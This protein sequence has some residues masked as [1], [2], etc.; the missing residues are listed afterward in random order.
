MADDKTAGID[1]W[2]QV[3]WDQHGSDLLLADDSQP[4]IRVDGKLRPIEGAPV[5]TGDAI[6]SVAWPLLTDGQREVFSTQMDVDFA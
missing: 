4:R 1:P 5:L 3:L 6:R 2:I